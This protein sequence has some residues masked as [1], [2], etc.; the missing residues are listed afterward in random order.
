MK[1]R[2]I[3]ANI[4]RRIRGE[5]AVRVGMTVSKIAGRKMPGSR[6]GRK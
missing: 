5:E 2:K 1:K 3:D 6:S 4:E